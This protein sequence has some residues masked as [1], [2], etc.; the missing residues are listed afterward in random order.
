[1]IK[2]LGSQNTAD[3][4]DRFAAEK[5]QLTLT[6]RD[7]TCTIT[8]GPTAPEISVGAWLQDENDPGAGIVWRVRS[9]Q[10]DYKTQTR[11][12]QCEHAIMALKDFLMFGEVTPAVI[13]GL[14][15]AETCTAE[16]TFRY[17]LSHQSIW[18]FGSVL[19]NDTQAYNFN[20]DDLYTAMETITATIPNAWWSYD[21]SRVPYVI[22]IV[23]K[24]ESYIG[25]L[26]EL[27][28]DRNM[29]SL[30]VTVDR[31]RMYTRFYPI[32]RNNLMLAEKYVGRNEN[33]YGIT[34]HTET[35]ENRTTEADLRKWANELLDNHAEPQVTISVNA[36]DLSAITGEDL[37]NFV[38]GAHCTVALPEYNTTIYERIMTLQWSNKILDPMG[39]TITMANRKEDL[40]R[41]LAKEKK[42]TSTGRRSSAV[43]VSKS[44]KDVT[45]SGPT[46]NVYTLKKV[47]T[48][49][50]TEDIG[51]FSRAVASWVVDV[52]T[53]GTIRVT[54]K[55][56]DQSKSIQIGQGAGS[57]DGNTYSGL[58]TYSDDDAA[59]WYSSG[60]YFTVDA[61]ARY[62]AGWDNAAGMSSPAPTWSGSGEHTSFSYSYPLKETDPLG[63]VTRHKVTDTLTLGKDSPS[64]SGYAKVLRGQALIARINVGN[65][66][67]SGWTAAWASSNDETYEVSGKTYSYNPT[68]TV[69]D[70]DRL[71]YIKVARPNAVVDGT[72]VANTY[73]VTTTKATAYIRAESSVGAIVA[74]N[75][76]YTYNSG[77]TAAWASSNDETYEVS[78]KTYNYNPITTVAE[79]DRLEY[80][81]V[82][83]PNAL[84]DGALAANTYY[85]VTTKANAYIRAES[86]VG[87]IVAANND[88]T[89]NSGWAAAW[90]ST[91]NKTYEVNSKT[92]NYNPVVTVAEADRLE[93]IKVARPN[94]VVDGA[95]AENTYY[96]VTTKAT[97]YI[98]AES[99]VGSIVAA[100]SDYTY[101]SG[102]AAAWGSTSNKT[103]E[104]S[105]KTYNYNPV[106]TVAEADR[107]GYIKVARPNAVVDG[108]LAENTYYVVTTKATAYIR[109]ESA[110]GSIVAANS[111]Y[112]Y[113]SGWAAAWGSTSNKTY[114]VASKTYNYNPVTGVAEADRL[115]YIKVIRANAVVDGGIDGTNTNTYYVTTTKSAAYIRAESAVGAIVA[116]NSDY[117]Y[118]SGWAAAWGSTSNKTYE[119]NGVTYDY[120]P[121]TT[122]ADANRLSYIKVARPNASVDGALAE[123][124]YYLVTT[125]SAAYIRAESAVGAIVAKNTDYT[126]D[127]GL[128][129]GK[130]MTGYIEPNLS[131][132]YGDNYNCVLYTSGDSGT[133]VNSIACG[134]Y[135]GVH[136]PLTENGADATSSNLQA[137]PSGGITANGNYRF[138]DGY[139]GI[140]YLKVNVSQ[141]HTPTIEYNTN[142]GGAYSLED[143]ED[144]LPS[145]ANPTRLIAG[146]LTSGR[147]YGFR[148]KCG[149]SYKYYYIVA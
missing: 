138:A 111:D 52:P 36:M 128:N 84:V 102:W 48:N 37:D 74:A 33:L 13:T 59:H 43:S 123:N 100:N 64:S 101:N 92:Y 114:E 82:A 69:A 46:D 96:V 56:Q 134:Q 91:S 145:G 129:Y 41:M 8:V 139:A 94:A 10:T 98:R 28:M 62:Y 53:G 75:S 26:S 7:S 16:Q 137:I 144:R 79:A 130:T 12:I 146:Q 99:K 29:K 133:Y 97:A 117:T 108:A 116:S 50:T 47:L 17:I 45:L 21:F 24:P 88:Y 76:D 54:A 58:I 125:S 71:S 147:Y 90:G 55:P 44:L 110:V 18:R 57:W 34:S 115:G 67:S 104:V 65:W 148:A 106:T 38:L 126:Y 72:L 40:T 11:T 73:Y 30:S 85:V 86:K 149:S 2:L 127:A 122:V 77:W 112:T 107:L 49:G 68:I 15:N 143:L 81:K 132:R 25:Q 1:M 63:N 42:K 140:R 105:S 39:V 60:K 80:I 83:R 23:E 61:T 35:D 70:A 31:S 51:T 27:R 135:R 95:L 118:D 87:S 32:G 119:V 103:Y 136:I 4:T 3:V 6:E 124:T 19:Y 78:G 5:F 93:Y 113:N 22:S 66:Y 141:T 131:A 142:W 20:G 109:A 14:E 120:N 9:V 89:Y 121:V